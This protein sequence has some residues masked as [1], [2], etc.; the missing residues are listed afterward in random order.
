V[1]TPA[2]APDAAWR[3]DDP[4]AMRARL[5]RWAA[6]EVAPG[7]TIG[8]VEHLP[9]HSDISWAFELGTADGTQRL[10]LRMPPLGARRSAANDVHRQAPL[11]A[12]LAEHGV[13]VPRVRWSSADGPWFGTP[14]LVVDRVAGATPGDVFADGGAPAPTG[15]VFAEAMRVLPHNHATAPPSDWR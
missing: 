10:V 1:S 15:A 2:D 11:L 12:A 3:Q 14:Y 9:G 8:A 7:A 6:D 13:P 5:V 4:S